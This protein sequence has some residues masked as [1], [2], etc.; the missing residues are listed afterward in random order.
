MGH[1]YFFFW[2]GAEAEK[3]APLYYEM[4]PRRIT[5]AEHYNHDD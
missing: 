2:P 1:E 5:L 4:A 3:L